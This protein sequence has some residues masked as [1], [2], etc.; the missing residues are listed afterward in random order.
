M[1][2]L[3]DLRNMVR[4]YFRYRNDPTPEHRRKLEELRFLGADECPSCSEVLDLSRFRRVDREG[5]VREWITCASCGDVFELTD[6]PV[7]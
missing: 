1:A 3:S 4:A 5:R 2:E 6:L 7:H